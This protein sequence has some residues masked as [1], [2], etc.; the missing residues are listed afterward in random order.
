MLRVG[1]A[2]SVIYLAAVTFV[3]VQARDESARRAMFG[4]VAREVDRFF[5]DHGGYPRS[6]Q[7]LRVD[8]F[9]DGSSPD[10]VA[11]FRYSSD[12]RS[13]QLVSDPWLRRALA[14]AGY[15]GEPVP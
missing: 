14:H 11:G 7:E 1:V 5:D 6:L 4:H 3:F 12:G 13:F 15:R 2:V 8:S 10:T 9:P